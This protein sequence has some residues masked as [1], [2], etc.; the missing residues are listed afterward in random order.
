MRMAHAAISYAAAGIDDPPDTYANVAQIAL[1][2]IT[3]YAEDIPR[4]AAA[5]RNLRS[6]VVVSVQT[7]HLVHLE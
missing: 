5:G 7:L 6:T 3:A 1:D 2:A 4:A